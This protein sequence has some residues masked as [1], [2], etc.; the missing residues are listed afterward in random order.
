MDV[1]TENSDP[2]IRPSVDPAIIPSHTPSPVPPP[3][4][5]Y[6][7]YSPLHVFLQQVMPTT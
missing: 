1:V 4:S 5:Q 7:S 3:I 2:L 6:Y